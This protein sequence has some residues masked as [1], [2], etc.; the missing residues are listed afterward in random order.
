M[1]NLNAEQLYFIDDCIKFLEEDI[2][3]KRHEEKYKI[4]RLNSEN[5]KDRAIKLFGI[6]TAFELIASLNFTP[7]KGENSITPLDYPGERDC[8]CSIISD[9]CSGNLDC[10]MAPS[11]PTSTGCG[12]FWAYACDGKCQSGI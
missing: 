11:D 6:N 1:S 7:L 4:F 3:S 10:W 2:Y 12:T 8:K 9:W 5:L